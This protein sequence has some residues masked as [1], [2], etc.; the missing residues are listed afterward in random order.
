MSLH[1]DRFL[2]TRECPAP[3][4]DILTGR[5]ACYDVYR[6][7]DGSWLA[8]AAIEPAF[9]ANLCKALGWS[10]GSSIR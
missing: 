6:A 4:A 5:Y 1:A 7:R 2:A 9:F 3:A 10:A 8:V